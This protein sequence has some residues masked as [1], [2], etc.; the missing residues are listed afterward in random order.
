MFENTDGIIFDLDGTLVDSMWIWSKIDIEFI[1]EKALE[2]T[3]EELMKEIAH[4]SF[5]ETAQ[6]FRDR[7]NME[8]TREEIAQEW[9]DKAYYEYTHNV[10]PK[11]GLRDFL[12]NMKKKNIRMAV[13]SSN[14]KKLVVACLEALDL[15]K[16]FEAVVTTDEA[17]SHSKS[18]PDV[19]LYAAD[20]LKT[21]PSKT[22]VFEDVVNAMAGARRAGMRVIG[23]KDRFQ[24]LPDS[25][26]LKVC[27][28]YMEDYTTFAPFI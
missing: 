2:I 15:I 18:D 10:K 28:A 25:E 22:I 3:P 5:M 8:E 19:F 1:K 12:E 9:M 4:F 11:N 23:I 24:T 27:D 6:Y 14:S 21:M 20:K 7:F 17:G 13:A 26:V 16:Y